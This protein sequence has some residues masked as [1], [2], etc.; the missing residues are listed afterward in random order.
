LRRI[1]DTLN[2]CVRRMSSPNIVL[3]GA[4]EIRSEFEAL[5]S[6]EAREARIG[7]ASAE[8]HASP[9]ELLEAA[10]P[11]LREFRAARERELV[12]RWREE[13]SRDGRASAGWTR[14][15]DAAS[16]GRVEVLLVQEGVN[17]PAYRC[18][19]CGRAQTTN[20][21]CPL[22]GAAMERRPDG[23]DLAVHQALVHGGKV[24]VIRDRRDLEP[25][26][27]IGALLRY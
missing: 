18:P 1:A 10:E 27:G 22:D 20:G 4:E 11:V 26:E 12:D 19:E 3:I 5:L 9:A 25:V 8:R 17:R 16:D 23:L 24:V 13:A 21:S 15:L 2:R 14:T 7:W 6:R